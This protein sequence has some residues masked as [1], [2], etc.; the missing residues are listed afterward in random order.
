MKNKLILYVIAGL[1]AL[2]LVFH[3]SYI[4]KENKDSKA[5]QEV[6]DNLAHE[7]NIVNNRLNKDVMAE[8]NGLKTKLNR[9]NREIEQMK[10]ENQLTS[11]EGKDIKK[12]VK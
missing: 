5:L 8:I 1:L 9:L 2:N 7:I 12:T 6:R 10:T 3:I 4:I 11:K